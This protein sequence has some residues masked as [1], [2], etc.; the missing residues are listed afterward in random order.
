MKKNYYR[1]I[2]VG[3]NTVATYFGTKS[4]ANAYFR[5]FIVYC[6]PFHSRTWKVLTF[7]SY[8]DFEDC[9][10]EVSVTYLKI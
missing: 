2:P 1:L 3:Y 10:N 9:I 5:R 4:N 6:A 8:A 7:T